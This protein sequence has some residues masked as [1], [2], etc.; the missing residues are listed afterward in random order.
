MARPP[1]AI[2]ENPRHQFLAAVETLFA[3]NETCSLVDAC[4]PDGKPIANDK[5]MFPLGWRRELGRTPNAVRGK[6]GVWMR[7]NPVRSKGSGKNGAVLDKD[8]G[9]ARYVL[10]E[11]DSLPL[12]DQSAVLWR[13][14]NDGHIYI[15]TL[16]DSAGKSLHALCELGAD[17]FGK[18]ATTLLLQL[19]NVFGVDR[20]NS[21]PSRL[22][23]APGFYRDIGR[24]AD[25][26]GL[27]RLLYLAPARP[28]EVLK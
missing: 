1:L 10:V 9:A 28:V 14:Q 26:D 6:G 12:L 11:F 22:T 24:R 20:G 7:S 15:R 13:L 2:P 16:V 4:S 18:K 23:R 25:S 3:G 8:I 17:A 19:H 27:Q 5:G 21:N